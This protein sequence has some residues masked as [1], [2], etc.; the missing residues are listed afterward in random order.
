MAPI[1]ERRPGMLAPPGRGGGGNFCFGVPLS[2]FLGASMMRKT[3]GQNGQVRLTSARRQ[4]QHSHSAR[5]APTAEG[6]LT[7]A[8]QS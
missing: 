4:V 1:R 7:A 5:P 8:T 3:R 6:H 2:A